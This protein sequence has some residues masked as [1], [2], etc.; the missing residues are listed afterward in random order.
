MDM[1][2]F[3][4]GPGAA[5]DRNDEY[6]REAASPTR[7]G[8]EDEGAG[9]PIEGEEANEHEVSE[10]SGKPDR[11]NKGQDD[12]AN[13]QVAKLGRTGT[14]L[15]NSRP[16][17]R[18]PVKENKKRKVDKFADI[19]EA[20]QLTRRRQLELAK[21]KVEAK[22]ATKQTEYTYKMQKMLDRKERRQERNQERVETLKSCS[23]CNCVK[24]E[25]W[26]LCF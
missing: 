18:R 11:C 23:C 9:L 14:K 17:T 6:G 7:W 10:D 13:K 5:S 15:G 22:Q 8:I 20:E 1:S 2:I 4:D 21:M 3:T 16:A 24:N 25:E 19:A 12:T 26:E